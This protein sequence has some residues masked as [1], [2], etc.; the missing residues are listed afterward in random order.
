MINTA[1][2]YLSLIK[3]NY[4]RVANRM[5][6]ALAYVEDTAINIADTT[7]EYNLDLQFP[8]T[9]DYYGNDEWRRCCCSKMYIVRKHVI[10]KGVY[11]EN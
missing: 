9:S 8:P 10:D 2:T 11:Y 4:D 7:E 3:I 1:A 5:N 6:P